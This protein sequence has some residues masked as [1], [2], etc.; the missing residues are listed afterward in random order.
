MCWGN[1]A[2]NVEEGD[3]Q[4]DDLEQVDIAANGLIVV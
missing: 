3:A 1:V 4:L 2:L